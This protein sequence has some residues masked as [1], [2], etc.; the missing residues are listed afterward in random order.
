MSNN[1]EC[2]IEVSP[3]AEDV[4]DVINAVLA[5]ADIDYQTGWHALLQKNDGDGKSEI[6]AFLLLTGPLGIC[7]LA[8]AAGQLAPVLQSYFKRTNH[9]PIK[10]KVS[11]QT[12]EIMVSRAEDLDVARDAAMELQCALLPKARKK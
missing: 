6:L 9:A 12:A 11:K 10:I 8:K 2:V 5:E 7:A 1:H 4:K 3:D